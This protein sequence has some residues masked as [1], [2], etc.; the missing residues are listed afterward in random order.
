M[1]FGLPPT[2]DCYLPCV[3]FSRSG[4]VWSCLTIPDSSKIIISLFMTQA[5]FRVRRSKQEIENLQ[6]NLVQTPEQS[7]AT[8]WMSQTSITNRYE[9]RV[10]NERRHVSFALMVQKDI[11]MR[12]T[13]QIKSLER[14]VHNL[15]EQAKRM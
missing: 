7:T 1:P 10:L 9:Q 12:N 8:A 5:T 6:E 11:D 14:R 15:E 2:D 3:Y 13:Q 4:T